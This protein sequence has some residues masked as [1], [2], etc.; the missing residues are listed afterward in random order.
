[1]PRCL[2]CLSL[3]L[4]LPAFGADGYR[5]TF[6]N[7][8]KRV[9]EQ[10][11][12]IVTAVYQTPAGQTVPLRCELK[13][14][15]TNVVLAGQ[16]AN[17]S[18]RGKHNFTFRIPPLADQNRLSFAIWM[19][20]D[21]QQSLCPIVHSDPIGVLS[22]TEGERLT[23]MR[24][25][26]KALRDKLRAART[27]AGLVGLYTPSAAELGPALADALAKRLKAA[28]YGI[29]KLTDAE[30]AN[31]YALAP[32]VVD[33]LVVADPRR[34]PAEAMQ[35]LAQY[36][37]HG[38]KLMLL[39]GPAFTTPLYQYDDRWLTADEYQIELAKGLHP[40]LAMD[41]EGGRVGDWAR[42]TNDAAAPSKVVEDQPGADGSKG[43]AK[44]EVA[45]LTGWDTFLAPVAPD[46]GDGRTY[47]CFWAKGD[48][49]TSALA[50]EWRET[51]GSR[52]I[53]TVPLGKEWRPYAVQP[54]AFKFWHDSDAKG[55]GGAGDLCH[56]EHGGTLTFGLAFTHTN[57]VG[58]GPHTIWLDNVGSAAPPPDIDPA[59]LA[60]HGFD[61]PVIETVSPQYKLYPVTNLASVRPSPNA[62][63]VPSATL[64][65]PKST[66]APVPRPQGTGLDKHRRWRYLPLL[67]C[68]DAEGKHVG[69][70]VTLQVTGT[71]PN[72]GGIV[73]NA[74]ITDPSFFAAD[75]T[76][77]WFAKLAA[78]VVDGV[79]LYEGGA[80]Y[81]ASFGDET[82]PCGAV[83]TNRGTK[84]ARVTVVSTATAGGKSLQEQRLEVTLKP[85][86]AK[87]VAAD[88]GLSKQ[89]DR[90]T[91]T[92]L[93]QRDG[94]IIDRLSHEVRIIHPPAEKH[95]LKAQDGLFLVD[96]TPW[97]A[98]G[99]NYMPSSGIGI[100]D[101]EYFE[102]WLD[103]QAYDPDIIE[104]D[105]SDCEAIGF[106][107]VSVFCYHRSLQGRNLLDL[108]ARCRDH[109]LK[110]NLSLR[111]G[112]PMDFLWD[113]MKEMVVTA[114]LAEDDNLIA[115][116]LAWEPHWGN[117]ARRKPF[118][119]AWAEWVTKTYGSVAAAEQAW[120]CP[121]P[122]EDG[123][124][125]NPSDQQL[126]TEGV[127]HQMVLDYRRFQNELL[128]ERY[129]KARELMRTIDPHHLVS[130]RMSI[131]GDPTT[132][133]GYEGYDFAGLANAVDLLEPEGYGRIGNWEKVKPGWFTTAYGRAVAPELPVLWAEFGHSVWNRMD[134]RD[135]PKSMEFNAEFYQDFYRMALKSGCNGTVCW[136][137]PGGYRVNERSDFGILNPDRSWRR[138][139]QV[140]HDWAP[141]L[142]APRPLPQPDVWI[143]FSL[144]ERCTGLHGLYDEVKDRFWQLVEDGHTPGLKL[145]Q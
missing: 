128:D 23:M 29:A 3:C 33:L 127:H 40:T 87:R 5:A 56:P 36:A 24:N 138:T 84:P 111:P 98:H 4:S 124:V 103:P 67:E 91:V 114:R 136:W 66:L 69:D 132:G 116:D 73:V 143:D 61:P 8:P 27:A 55:R 9:I 109:G 102:Y 20:T 77:E 120:G 79:F 121:V 19:G 46:C 81:Y 14:P 106:N 12:L 76:R 86:E 122:R 51:D 88:L 45:D 68:L 49:R 30:A 96:G 42:S 140:I 1:M 113:E 78:R 85:G 107:L 71:D 7:L 92:T 144:T 26:A 28:G 135:D 117:H 47:L 58:S 95:Y 65:Q 17:V 60:G 115:Y 129:G 94:R 2:L 82:I 25:Q 54:S 145:R 35:T 112:T 15:V 43:C 52:W 89:L 70:C 130:F 126:S 93:L 72:A 59:L 63:I 37:E 21:W 131:G 83:V 125:T 48:A 90:V 118:D 53:A 101:R 80:A 31:P 62:A 133:P 119:A 137:F 64:P 99:V 74:P 105:L 18:G 44:I 104:R 38:G 10:A 50:I 134:G 108:L 22:V 139:T 13:N 97:Y 141:Q 39:G 41:F 32:E 142:T 75:A 11:E 6:D 100:E 16:V 110:V 57:Q 34:L 123:V